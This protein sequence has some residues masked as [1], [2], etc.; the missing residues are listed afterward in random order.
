VC[1]L[2]TSLW[3]PENLNFFPAP[4]FLLPS[5]QT[6]FDSVFRPQQTV[7]V[8]D[9]YPFRIHIPL[10][11]V[12]QTYSTRAKDEYVIVRNDALLKCEVPSFVADLVSVV[13]WVDSSGNDLGGKHG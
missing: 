12:H 6:V 9:L 3:L 11:A 1:K 8:S 7:K 5:S 10:V 4:L 2:G 13:G